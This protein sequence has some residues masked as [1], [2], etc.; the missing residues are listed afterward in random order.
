M[1]DML[2]IRCKNPTLCSKEGTKVVLTDLNHNNQTDFVLSSRAFAG[3]AQKGMGQQ[4]LKLGIA[5]IE[6]KRK[7]E[8]GENKESHEYL[9]FGSES[10]GK[11]RGIYTSRVHSGI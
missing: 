9:L 3:M 6:Y 2:Q 8:E 4:I 5:E 11:K 10:K 1:D 7:E